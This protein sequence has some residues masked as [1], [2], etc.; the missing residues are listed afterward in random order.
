MSIGSYV[1]VC[2]VSA[3][4]VASRRR[5]TGCALV[6]GVQ[7]CALPISGF[8]AFALSSAL[9]CAWSAAGALKASAKAISDRPDFIYVSPQL[10][11]GPYAARGEAARLDR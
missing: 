5:H 11:N 2:Y 7:T 3:F 8:S 10:R 9:S 6:T 4:F 1:V